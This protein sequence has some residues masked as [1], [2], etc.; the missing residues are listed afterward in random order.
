MDTTAELF[1]AQLP[2][3]EFATLAAIQPPAREGHGS[4]GTMVLKT[5]VS[6][7]RDVSL[8]TDSSCQ[9]RPMNH[10]EKAGQ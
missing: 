10:A 6:T 4:S 8:V 3:A 5:C 2:S 1:A 7:L 9:L